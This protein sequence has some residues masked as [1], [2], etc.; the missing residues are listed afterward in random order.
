MVLLSMCYGMYSH[1]KGFVVGLRGTDG[2][3]QGVKPP[4]HRRPLSS[5]LSSPAALLCCRRPQEGHLR[6][7]HTG[8]PG[9]RPMRTRSEGL[10]FHA[11]TADP[12]SA[13]GRSGDSGH[14]AANPRGLGTE[15][16]TQET[17]LSDPAGKAA[18]VSQLVS[19]SVAESRG[20]Q[21]RGAWRGSRAPP[22]WCR[23]ATLPL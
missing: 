17:T 21:T 23:A 4:L 14:K 2:R 6:S 15:S 7:G 18:R 11:T 1:V 12:R 8:S 10:M 3:F 19:F 5:F 9:I 13:S 16:P 22:D 20:P